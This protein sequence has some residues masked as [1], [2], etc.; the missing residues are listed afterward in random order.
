[1]A[2]GTALA[3]GR[4]GGGPPGGGQGAGPPMT[5]PGQAG[6]GAGT[7]DIARDLGPQ[8]GQ[9]GRDLADE[10][11]LMTGERQEQRLTADERRERAEEFRARGESQRAEALELARALAEAERRGDRIPPNAA[12]RLR[13]ALDADLQE[14][15]QAFQVERSEWQRM[16]DEWLADRDSLTPLEWAQRRADWFAA[17]D[18]WI[19]NQREWASARGR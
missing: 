16:R 1:M 14:W 15:R 18:A 6:A 12:E 4:G 17:R 3:Q 7:A 5:P 19:A 8:R 10:Q 13:G 11:R 2:A 9:F